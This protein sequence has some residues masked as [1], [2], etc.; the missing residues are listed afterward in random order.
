MGF[1]PWNTN[2]LIVMPEG[3]AAGFYSRWYDGSVDW[4]TFHLIELWRLLER[5]FHADGHRAVA[6]LSM[7]G[8]GSLSYAA[9]HS[10]FFQAAASYSGL[11]DT[12]F[13]G[14][15]TTGAIQNYLVGAG[16]DKN[17]LWAI[18]RHRRLS[19]PRTTR[20]TRLVGYAAFRSSCPPETDSQGRSTRPGWP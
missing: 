16:S 9:R 11:V 4:E 7:G 1:A 12:T 19:G 3:G 2:A 20:T 15:L 10:G 8:L 17:A 14:P 6:G 5:E 18:R 13:Q